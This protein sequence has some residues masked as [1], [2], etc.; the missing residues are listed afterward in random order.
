ME[1]LTDGYN[2]SDSTGAGFVQLRLVTVEAIPLCQIMRPFSCVLL[3]GISDD[4][5]L[6]D[7]LGDRNLSPKYDCL[8]NLAFLGCNLWPMGIT[9][10]R[11]PM[12]VLFNCDW[13]RVTRCHF[14]NTCVLADGISNVRSL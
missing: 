2:S 11:V 14:V 10:L 7:V 4:R 9:H 12:Q 1:I 5:S 8:S 6:E 13:L 3:D